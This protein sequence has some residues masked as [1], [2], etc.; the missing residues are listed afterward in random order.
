MLVLTSTEL[1]AAYEY[2]KSIG[3]EDHMM[4]IAMELYE[5]YGIIAR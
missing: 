4:E 2:A 5:K 3:D 1:L